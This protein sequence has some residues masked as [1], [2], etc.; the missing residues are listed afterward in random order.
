MHFSYTSSHIWRNMMNRLLLQAVP[1]QQDI[2][3]SAF[4]SISLLLSTASLGSTTVDTTLANNNNKQYFT[5]MTLYAHAIINFMSMTKSLQIIIPKS[6]PTSVKW[7]RMTYSG[8]NTLVWDWVVQQQ[9]HFQWL[10]EKVSLISSEIVCCR[11]SSFVMPPFSSSKCQISSCFMHS[12]RRVTRL[13]GEIPQVGELGDPRGPAVSFEVDVIDFLC[14]V[15]TKYGRLGGNSSDPCFWDWY[16]WT[17][18]SKLLNRIQ[19]SYHVSLS[20]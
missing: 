6:V 20:I 7:S 1:N 2:I 11:W 17:R 5:F 19:G 8:H 15:P 9:S 16:I 10:L 13:L 18:A 14:F 4:C 3:R 12:V